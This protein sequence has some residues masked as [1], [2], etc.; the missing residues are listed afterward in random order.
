MN[1]IVVDDEV[2]ARR[3]IRQYLAGFETGT[4]RECE[5]V[6]GAVA[7]IR[8]E[9]PDLLF[10]DV[11]LRD[12]TAFDVADAIGAD[13]M[14][15][16]IF[17]TAWDEHAVRAFELNAIDYLLKPFSRARFETAVKRALERAPQPSA[18]RHRADTFADESVRAD[19]IPEAAAG[20]APPRTFLR[21]ILVRMTDG[22]SEL[23]RVADIEWLEAASN[24]VCLHCGKR[25]Y[26]H[27]HTLS[28]LV[29]Q[30]DPALF[31]RVHRSAAV[32]LECV[33][34]ISPLAGG[35][36]TIHLRTGEKV[37]LS[38]HYR[39]AFDQALATGGTSFDS[40]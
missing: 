26:M 13:H 31:V 37:R 10:L 12:G 27:R 6:A 22:A 34:R 5:D 2:N 15:P 14:P 1:V 8:A 19:A 11:Q 25:R 36:Y 39:D 30:M 29:S 18:A 4:I 35:D 16:T 38:R 40:P 3:K 33:A 20:A 28:A 9:S 17:V 32:N 23:V 7:A 24:Y 21:W